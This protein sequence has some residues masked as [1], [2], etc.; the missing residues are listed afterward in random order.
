[1]IV[2]SLPGFGR[3]A[4]FA[5]IIAEQENRGNA[6]GGGFRVGQHARRRHSERLENIL[7]NEIRMELAGYG[8]DND[9]KQQVAAIAIVE[10]VA[11]RG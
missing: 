1:M 9:A 2:V 8:A 6:V 5:R 3:R 7:S 10:F 4:Q 11:R